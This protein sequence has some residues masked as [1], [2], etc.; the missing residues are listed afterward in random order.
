M[1]L[2]I[3]GGGSIGQ[4]HAKNARTLGHFAAVFDTDPERGH[5]EAM[6]S[7]DEYEAVLICTPAS[8][9]EDV[10]IAL[11]DDG[12]RGPL[13]VEKPLT[14]STRATI[15]RAW[16]H[17]VTMTGYNWR[18]HPEIAPLEALARR[19]A[20]VHFDCRTDMRTWP[21]RSYGPPVLECSH[22]IDLACAWL[23]DPIYLMGGALTDAG[24]W[25]Q[26]Q[27]PRGT[28]VVDIRWQA[29]ALRQ[30]TIHCQGLTSIHARMSAAPIA[31]LPEVEAPA[32]TESYVLEL[33]HFLDCVR[34]GTPTACPFSDGLR[35]VGI[36]E[37][38]KE[39]MAA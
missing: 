38:L 15:F 9:H 16:P 30:L 18:F 4:R 33:Q 37:R 5:H 6:F 14:L 35:V 24:A 8:T 21:G 13:F 17:L 29:E 11:L 10:A 20:S 7:P 22:E 12:Y 36:C 25:L 1:N 27:H 26:M 19:Q 23:G 39:S 34:A 2:A 28:S 3:F 32:L 31:V